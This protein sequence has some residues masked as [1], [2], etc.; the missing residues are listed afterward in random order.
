[1]ASIPMK[2]LDGHGGYLRWKES[3]LL[4]L[5]TVGVAHVLFEDRPAGSGDDDA[6][7]KKWARDDAIC[8]G[9]ILATLSDRL[10]PDYARFATAAD[11]WRALARTYDVEVRRAW[12]DKFDGFRFEEGGPLLLLEQL[13]HAEALG[14]AGKLS[15]D[16]MAAA[17]CGGKLPLAVSMPVMSRS[18][19]N[20]E[21]GMNLI[22]DVARRLTSAGVTQEF[23]WEAEAAMADDQG[24]SYVD[25][26]SPAGQDRECWNCGQPG[27]IARN[28]RA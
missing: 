4:R 25:G 5:H 8:R 17:L 6:A 15:D 7:A 9:H 22:W 24:G 26:P 21:V 14:V 23:L 13:A 28:C 3:V 12:R 1:M 19:P 16:L 18:G 10:L 27:H 11:L 2:Q 20:I